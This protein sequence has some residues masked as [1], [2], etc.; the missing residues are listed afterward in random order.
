MTELLNE[1]EM[2]LVRETLADERDARLYHS[3]PDWPR[4]LLATAEA[5]AK[6]QKQGIALTIAR[7]DLESALGRV[8]FLLNENTTL[9]NERDYWKGERNALGSTLNQRT[10]ELQQAQ[11]AEQ[12]AVKQ[13]RKVSDELGKT[14]AHLVDS[15]TTTREVNRHLA[16]A[17][18]LLK[19]MKDGHVDARYT[20]ADV[21]LTSDQVG[22][23]VEL[24]LKV[25]LATWE[26]IGQL[27]PGSEH[28]GP[29]EPPK[30]LVQA[31]F[32]KVNGERWGL[33]CSECN[34]EMSGAGW[35]TPLE[36]QTSINH[37]SVYHKEDVVQWAPLPYNIHI[38]YEKRISTGPVPEPLYRFVCSYSKHP[39]E[40]GHSI[41]DHRIEHIDAIAKW[42]VEDWHRD[43]WVQYGPFP[44]PPEPPH[45]HVWAAT[46][47]LSYRCAEKGCGAEGEV[48]EVARDGS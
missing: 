32:K 7:Q 28:V 31:G 30:R 20:G 2:A 18:G 14:Q 17:Y 19:E 10:M 26:R 47:P 11:A 13:M 45:V 6:R 1:S 12:S 33:T 9:R 34:Q 37:F 40:S 46:G 38:D 27:F 44:D 22:K 36:A 15:R 8:D 25:P 21:M 3:I 4:R 29:P 43:D 35:D 16:E 39:G 42:H 23:V 41:W 48:V 24:Y 5:N